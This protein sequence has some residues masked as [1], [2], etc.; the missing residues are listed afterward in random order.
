MLDLYFAYFYDP[1]SAVVDGWYDRFCCVCNE[2]GG[3][4]RQED[5]DFL[6]KNHYRY[7][8]HYKQ[9]AEPADVWK[10]ARFRQ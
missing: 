5:Y 8:G 6:V 9:G 7:I 2:R 3:L 4:E 1:H 10:P